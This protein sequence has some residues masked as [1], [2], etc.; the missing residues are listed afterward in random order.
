MTG[1]ASR[2]TGPLEAMREAVY[3]FA[4]EPHARPGEP[5]TR[6]GIEAGSPGAGPGPPPPRPLSASAAQPGPGP[7]QDLYQQAEQ[8][9]R[10]DR[11][12]AAS[13]RPG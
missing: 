6:P 1:S 12:A 7:G 9:G 4:R 11:R 5:A 10:A 3:L 13:P 2:E 8:R